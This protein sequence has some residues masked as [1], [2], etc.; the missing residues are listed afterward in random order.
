MR[1]DGKVALARFLASL[2]ARPALLRSAKSAGAEFKAVE[3]AAAAVG[4]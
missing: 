4:E 3:W 2:A 1:P